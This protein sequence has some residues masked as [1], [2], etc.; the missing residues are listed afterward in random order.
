[1]ET[2]ETVRVSVASD[3]P[4]ANGGNFGSHYPY[5]TADGRYLTFGSFA[6]NLVEGDTNGVIDVFVRDLVTGE[7]SRVSVASDGTQGNADSFSPSSISADGR[8]V[9]F[10]SDASNLVLGDSNGFRDIF[11]HDRLTG[12]TECISIGVDKS[13]QVSLSH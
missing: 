12:Q 8:Y 10:Y 13:L 9:A 6:S 2:G 1:M 7:T 5:L 3:G 4:E 11:V